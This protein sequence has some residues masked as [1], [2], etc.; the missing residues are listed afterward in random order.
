L[1]HIKEK[2][3]ALFVVDLGSDRDI[4]HKVFSILPMAVF[5]RSMPASARL[6]M[7]SIFEGKERT[8]MSGAA[9]VKVSTVATI[10]ATG[11]PPR[12]EF[13]PPKG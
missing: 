6:E 4:N 3:A 9:T 13:L 7:L 12:D 1:I 2:L 10:P 11:S 5:P 8:E